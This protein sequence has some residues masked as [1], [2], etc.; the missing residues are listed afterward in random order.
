M[1]KYDDEG[2]AEDAVG[3]DREWVLKEISKAKFEEFFQAWEVRQGNN[4]QSSWLRHTPEV[5]RLVVGNVSGMY[6]G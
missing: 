6:V 2:E 1:C 3:L 4:A 5:A